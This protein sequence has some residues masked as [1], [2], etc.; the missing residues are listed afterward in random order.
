MRQGAAAERDFRST[1][2]RAGG[3]AVDATCAAR[4]AAR[5]PIPGRHRRHMRRA[6]AALERAQEH[7]FAAGQEPWL[8]P[9]RPH[10]QLELI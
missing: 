9:P 5:G 10:V 8:L 2:D 7:L 3:L 1:V 6:I 4:A